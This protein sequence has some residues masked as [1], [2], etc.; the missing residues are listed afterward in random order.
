LKL[1]LAMDQAGELKRE[2]SEA[3]I[4]QK[5]EEEKKMQD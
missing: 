3:A 1:T 2:V 5:T 4:L